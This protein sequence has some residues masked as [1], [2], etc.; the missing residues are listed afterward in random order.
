MKSKLTILVSVIQIV[1]SLD[2][3]KVLYFDSNAFVTI[4]N[5]ET[6]V[7]FSVTLPNPSYLAFA[8]LGQDQ[9]AHSNSDM[10]IWQAS[11]SSY[12]SF[13]VDLYSLNN[14]YPVIDTVQDYVSDIKY[15]P[16]TNTV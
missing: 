4:E 13:C 15:F 6:S 1:F 16:L 12:S 5:T 8:F 7:T 3:Q 9:Q 10:V 11:G 14:T 2:V